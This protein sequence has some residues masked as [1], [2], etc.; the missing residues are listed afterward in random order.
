[1]AFDPR[2]VHLYVYL[3]RQTS[4]D[5]LLVIG[6][7]V[8]TTPILQLRLCSYLEIETPNYIYLPFLKMFKHIAIPG[9]FRINYIV[10]WM[11]VS[12]KVG[13][14]VSYFFHFKIACM[15]LIQFW[16]WLLV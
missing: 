12:L 4:V 13:L 10:E 15:S 1:M 3:N 8:F 16:S 14:Y 11:N 5:P 7:D 6:R 2:F 9:I